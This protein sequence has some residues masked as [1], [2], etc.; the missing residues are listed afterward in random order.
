[1]RCAQAFSGQHSASGFADARRGERAESSRPAKIPMF[2]KDS[3]ASPQA[4][5]YQLSA[6][7]G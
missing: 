2:S 5:S 1:M 6:F 7:S 3:A 4:V